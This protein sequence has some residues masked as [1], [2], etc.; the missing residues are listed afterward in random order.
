MRPIKS[1]RT[2]ANITCSAYRIEQTLSIIETGILIARRMLTKLSRYEI[3]GAR[4]GESSAV[5]NAATVVFAWQ[6][7]TGIVFFG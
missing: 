1:I 5:L 3:V 7:G 4:A 6:S 2:F